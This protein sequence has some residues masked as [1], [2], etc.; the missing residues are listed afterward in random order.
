MMMRYYMFVYMYMHM[1]MYL[2]I[3]IYD[4]CDHFLLSIII[5]CS[6]VNLQSAC[7][8]VSSLMQLKQ[9]PAL[10]AIRRCIISEQVHGHVVRPV[11]ACTD[12]G[13]MCFSACIFVYTY[14]I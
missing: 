7:T 9:M 12:W 6:V 3:V 4:C 2:L 1:Y 11:V 10:G 8:Y 13:S 5:Y 14:R